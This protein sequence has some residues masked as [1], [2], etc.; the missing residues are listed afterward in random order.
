[1][2]E[3]VPQA[4]KRISRTG[5]EQILGRRV[6]QLIE[7]AWRKSNDPRNSVANLCE[8]ELTEIKQVL[9]ASG[10]GAIAWW[11]IRNTPLA[12]TN[13]G[14]QLHE[15]YRRFRLAALV[16][17]REIAH[18]FELLDAA[19]IDA[20][21]VKGWAIAHRYPDR[22][23]RP[24]GDIDLCIRP[25]Q[26]LEAG[27]VLKCLERIEGHYFDL[28]CGFTG[29]GQTKPQDGGIRGLRGS[30]RFR[31]DSAEMREWRELYQR[32]GLRGQKSDF[33]GFVANA[34]MGHG[35]WEMGLPVLSDEDHLR[36]LC[37]HMLRSGARR[38]MWLCDI[39]LLVESLRRVT[40]NTEPRAVA[41]GSQAAITH[42]S[43][44]TGRR[45][46]ADADPVAAAPGCVFVDPRSC[47]SFDW[48]TCLGSNPVH[49]EWIG[50]ALALAHELLGAD[51]SH[52]PFAGQQAPRWVVAEVLEQWG[53]KAV[54]RRQTAGGKKT[55]PKSNVQSPKSSSGTQTLDF[56]HWTLDLYRR[57]DNPIRATA[58]VGGKFSDRPQLRYRVAEL[59]ARLP[60]LRTMSSKF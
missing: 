33:R 8:A 44:N 5:L 2:I 30:H 45:P 18:V 25:D 37:V 22:G 4:H 27:A 15:I 52:T 16:H 11:Q 31:N 60:E 46:S 14:H 53:G 57:W 48:Q 39:A 32:S 36:L 43:L 13:A 23:L 12:N 6:A 28:H 7:G 34:D 9:A 19:G 10:A 26:F 58:A 42:T 41:T 38:P 21:L 40:T 50:L 51:I 3:A 56:G 35:A 54:G 47:A 55:S 29:I 17:E 20:V 1:L 59:I 49:R 24:Y